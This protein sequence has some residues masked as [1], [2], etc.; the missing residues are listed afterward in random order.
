MLAYHLQYSRGVLINIFI[1]KPQYPNALI[2]QVFIADS[3]PFDSH[4]SEVGFSIQF[5]AKFFAW[6]KE[7]KNVIAHAELSPEPLALEL[8]RLKPFPQNGFR[9]RAVISQVPTSFF[10]VFMVV[11]SGAGHNLIYERTP[12]YLPLQGEKLGHD[13]GEDQD[14]RKEYL[15]SI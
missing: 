11:F 6:A 8:F 9:W 14:H 2:I 15:L 12:L 7:I 13:I 3:I 1:V 4:L 10:Q 5:H